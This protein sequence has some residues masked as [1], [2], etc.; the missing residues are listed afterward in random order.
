MAMTNAERQR[1]YRERNRAKLAAKQRTYTAEHPEKRS[2][3]NR[4]YY[5]KNKYDIIFKQIADYRRK[6]NRCRRESYFLD[7]AAYKEFL[8]RRLGFACAADVPLMKD[9]K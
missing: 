6:T 9:H 8:A 4:K 5:K 3:T 7:D 2:E 1:K